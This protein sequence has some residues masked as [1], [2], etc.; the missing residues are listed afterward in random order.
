M[1]RSRQLSAYLTVF[2]LAFAAC[3]G[4]DED[5]RPQPTTTSPSTT[6]SQQQEDEQALRHLAEDWYETYSEIFQSQGDGAVAVE[7]LMDPYL[8]QFQAQLE[9]LRES[10]N[11]T[12]RNNQSRQI[13]EQ[14]TVDGDRAVVTECVVNANVLKSSDG[15]VINDEVTVRRLETRAVRTEEGWRFTERSVLQ[16]LEGES[17]CDA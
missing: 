1:S 11:E 4:D 8:A 7:F 15:Q 6:Q 10:G 13:V 9:D 2:C 5:A 14:I 16:E 12:V 3:G 17:E